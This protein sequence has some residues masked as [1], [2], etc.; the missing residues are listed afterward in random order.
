M[1]VPKFPVSYT[2][3][4]EQDGT[5]AETRLCLS[6][7]RTSPCNLVGV[8]AFSLG[9]SASVKN[10]QGS[11]STLPYACMTSCLIEHRDNFTFTFSCYSNG[12]LTTSAA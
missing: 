3:Y 7:K 10:A 6:I 12:L 2:L 11:T 9:T 8:V 4:L 5:H 1:E